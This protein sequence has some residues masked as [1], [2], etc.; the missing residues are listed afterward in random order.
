M[1]NTI[2]DF[3]NNLRRLYADEMFSCRVTRTSTIQREYQNRNFSVSID[4]KYVFVLDYNVS[5]EDELV[6]QLLKRGTGS[7]YPLLEI[8]MKDNAEQHGR[9]NDSA[10]RLLKDANEQGFRINTVKQKLKEKR[11]RYH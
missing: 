5:N 9:Q 2:I 6:Y 7:R 3:R 10:I 11:A 8:W 4:E 1:Q